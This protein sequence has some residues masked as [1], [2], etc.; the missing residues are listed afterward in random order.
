VLLTFSIHLF[1]IHIELLVLVVTD[2]H[3]WKAKKVGSNKVFIQTL[4]SL[5]PKKDVEDLSKFGCIYSSIH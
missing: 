1:Y 4:Y 5:C 3:K 2:E